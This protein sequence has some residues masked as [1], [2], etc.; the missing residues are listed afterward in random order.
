MLRDLS[1][2]AIFNGIL[3]AFVGAASSFAIILSGLVAVGATEAQAATGLMLSFITMGLAG[4]VAGAVGRIPIGV[5]WSTPGAALLGS[6]AVPD[7][8]FPAVLGA[9]VVC[10]GLIIASGLIRPF[11]RLVENIPK[12]L[13]AALIAGVLIQ[14]CF[15]PF[16]GLAQ[17]P[18]AV[19]AI[20]LAW[21]VV[22]VVSPRWAVP[23][24]LI[25][26]LIVLMT[27]VDRQPVPTDLALFARWEWIWPHFDVPTSIGLGVPLFI[28]TMAGQNIPGVAV[29]R[30]N[31]YQIK[32]G[33][34]FTLTGIF[35]AI[36]APFGGVAVNLA[37][38][39]AAMMASEQSH[40]DP[41]RRYWASISAGIVYVIFGIFTGAIV[42]VVSLA[43]LY[44]IQAVAGLA[45][46]PA[47]V[48]GVATAFESPN[49][50]MSAAVTFLFGASGM[51]LLGISGAFWGLVA[52]LGID[53]LQRAMTQRRKN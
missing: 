11:G 35:S 9:F 3:A 18:I 44:L 50:R 14:L 6:S 17:A 34:W 40:A 45:L 20:V 51:A 27:L 48:A 16:D 22:F 15:A 19:G 13:A 26:F 8:G 37:A 28:V 33:P 46:I 12:H 52:G 1:L 23:V 25:V 7:A 29:M 39:T 10:A 47:F 30:T 4:I 43:P 49:R 41:A 53:G 32:A 24:A 21:V 38:I 5:A 2:Q 36:G 31:N 42:V